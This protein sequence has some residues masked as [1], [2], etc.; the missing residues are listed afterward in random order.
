[1][2]LKGEA[3][4]RAIAPYPSLN[5][6]AQLPVVPAP[7]LTGYRLRIKLMVRQTNEGL[8]FGLYRRGS[9]DFEP[10]DRCPVTPPEILA[11][12]PKISAVL[13]RQQSGAPAGPVKALDL[14]LGHGSRPVALTLVLDR[15]TADVDDLPLAALRV[16]CPEVDVIAVNL[17]PGQSPLA[18]GPQTYLI[19]GGPRT[20]I[21][22]SNRSVW[23]SPGVFF[24]ANRA[25]TE[26]I[27]QMLREFLA[28]PEPG[29]ELLD[30][31][32]GAGV[33]AL[34]LADLFHRVTGVESSGPSVADAQESARKHGIRHAEFEVADAAVV[35]PVFLQGR[36][37]AV[38]VNP[39][40]AGCDAELRDALGDQ[41]PPK[42]AYISCNP[43]SLA[44]DLHHLVRRGFTLR[45]LMP[46]DMMPLTDH[47]ETLAL[48]ERDSRTQDGAKYPKLR[49]NA[50]QR[51]M[52]LHPFGP[53]CIGN[54]AA[55]Q[56]RWLRTDGEQVFPALA[57]DMSGVVWL[58]KQGG[59]R[60][61]TYT[62]EA[63]V[64]GRIPQHGRIPRPVLARAECGPDSAITFRRLAIIDTHS[65]VSVRIK[66]APVMAVR[67]ALRQFGFPVVGDK[68]W[69]NRDVNHYFSETYSLDRTFFHVTEI[70]LP[71]APLMMWP[72]APDLSAVLA[73]AAYRR[74]QRAGES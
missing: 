54:G 62:A 4:A 21:Q 55:H 7:A 46:V 6:A 52:F 53:A 74:S 47:V 15:E 24:Q 9:R 30:L 61:Q 68:A 33:H 26:T 59:A 50:G 28:R 69:G 32:C 17:N 40:R 58:G 51:F 23:L 29:G 25:Q 41:P 18:L 63:L 8:Q 38:I 39:P 19:S 36:P 22:I 10:V 1:L 67:A 56:E 3:V 2:R 31:Y 49:A 43:V 12:L 5:R 71:E 65:L 35:A 34:V 11:V 48:L 13:E 72:L 42:L 44:R 14:R 37:S 27:H 16:A 70:G 64:V 57:A 60:P 45:R 66:L 20:E 73:Q